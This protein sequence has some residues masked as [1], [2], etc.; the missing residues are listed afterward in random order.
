MDLLG[1]FNDTWWYLAD[2]TEGT[3]DTGSGRRAPDHWPTAGQSILGLI[4][5]TTADRIEYS[6]P[7]GEVIAVYEPS[8]K[9]PP[10][11]V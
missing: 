2:A 11:C 9:Q 8:G 1:G 3:A 6:I 10:G 4:T 5:L 7:G